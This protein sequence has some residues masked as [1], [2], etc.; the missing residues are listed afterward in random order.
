MCNNIHLRFGLIALLLD[1]EGNKRSKLNRIWVHEMLLKRKTE[2][3]FATL[4]RELIDNEMKFYIY[5]RMFIQQFVI[6]LSKIQ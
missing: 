6:L 3:T 1:E 2:G 5:F 4:Y